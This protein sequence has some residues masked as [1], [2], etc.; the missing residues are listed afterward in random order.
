MTMINREK[1]KNTA[2]IFTLI[3]SIMFLANCS[4]NSEKKELPK[5]T[6]TTVANT[7]AVPQSNT[8]TVAN[9]T[10]VKDDN[11]ADDIRP[12]NSANTNSSVKKDAD[13]LKGKDAD[14]VRK[15]NSNAK[16]KDKDDLNKKGDADDKG[17]R[18][19]SDGD[20]DDN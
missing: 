12:T 15:P 9:T 16:G 14:D 10:V 7:V 2:I 20:D 6:N 8:Q 19:D 11:D 1:M 17:K 13:D 4:G 5:T 18:R 3:I